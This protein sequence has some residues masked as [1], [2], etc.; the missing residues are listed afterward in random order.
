MS[1]QRSLRDLT[2]RYSTVYLA[3]VVVTAVLG[4]GA[5]WLWQEASSE[6]LRVNSMVQEV[7]IMRGNLYRQM[8]ELFDTTFL[9]DPNAQTQYTLY[10]G[11]I[12]DGLYRLSERAQGPEEEAAGERRRRGWRRR[13]LQG[14]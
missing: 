10:S 9:D 4:G 12:E 2:L 11:L 3:L 14:R 13:E 8:K 5:L 7:E 1:I 6:S